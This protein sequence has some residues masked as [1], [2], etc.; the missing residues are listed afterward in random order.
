MK[1][2]K[3]ALCLTTL[4]CIVLLTSMISSVQGVSQTYELNQG[5]YSGLIDFDL[6]VGDQVEGSFLVSNLGPYDCV[7]SSGT[8]Y[9]VVDVWVIP[10]SGAPPNGNA[11][12]NFTATP[13]AASFNFNFTAKDNGTYHFYTFSGAMDYLVNA[14]NPSITINYEIITTTAPSASPD[15]T[16]NVPEFPFAIVLSLSGLILLITVLVKKSCPKAYN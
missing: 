11:I 14:K 16:P 3:A 1:K 5:V 9:E 4:L 13:N 6:Q 12:L 2:I 8:S 15:S 7:F 10:P